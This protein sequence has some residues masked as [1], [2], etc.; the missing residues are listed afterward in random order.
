[1]DFHQLEAFYVIAR[2]K[3]FSRAAE[4]L[5]LSQSAISTRISNLESQLNVSLFIRN[6]RLLKL[7]KYGE[8]FEPYVHQILNLSKDAQNRLEQIKKTESSRIEIGTMSSIATYFLPNLL[9]PFQIA[10]PDV[11]ISIETVRSEKILENLESGL[12]QIGIVNFDV[13]DHRFVKIPLMQHRIIVVTTPEHPVYQRLREEPEFQLEW[14]RETPI[15]NFKNDSPYYRSFM[16]LLHKN[17][18]GPKQ[19]ITVNN[20]EAI[21]RMAKQQ[22]GVAFLPEIAVQQELSQGT[23]VEIPIGHPELF[24]ISSYL[25]Y[26]HTEYVSPVIPMFIS[27]VQNYLKQKITGNT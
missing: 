1:M 12:I 11:Q 6:G 4:L 24:T 25:V 14:A 10:M 26:L 20:Q 16:D 2:E 9:Q 13:D 7:S 8:A 27:V 17:N 5:H 19:L 15:I 3:S 22:V 18:I 23:L 21:K